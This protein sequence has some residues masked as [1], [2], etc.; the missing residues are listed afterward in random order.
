MPPPR[1]CPRGNARGAPW[2]VTARVRTR[3]DQTDGADADADAEHRKASRGDK[4]RRN[5]GP[6]AL[7]LTRALLCS[8][9]LPVFSSCF[10]GLCKKGADVCESLH[11][12]DLSKM[13]FCQFVIDYG[14]CHNPDCLFNHARPKE[15]E[16]K[17]CIW[18]ARGF[19]K[20]GPNCKSRHRKREMCPDYLAGFCEL[21]PAC[22]KGHPKW[23]LPA[24]MDLGTPQYDSAGNLIPGSDQ[25]RL[26]SLRSLI[27]MAMP[28][29]NLL[30]GGSGGG[31]ATKERRTQTLDE[32]QCNL[33]KQFGHMA[34]AC[35]NAPR[36]PPGLVGY[37]HPS[38]GGGGGVVRD[39]SIV[40]CF[41][42]GEIG[43]YANVCRGEKREPPEGG[44]VLPSGV[45][46]RDRMNTKRTRDNDGGL[47]AMPQ[48]MF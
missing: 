4:V 6:G 10:L 18:Y 17:D 28:T 36:P 22:P 3:L 20:L 45:R 33:C 34:G 14:S 21:G 11:I 35:P 1:R 2:G 9:C 12:Y 25:P 16:V 42:C 43:H 39:L 31:G 26:R 8:V 19:C 40:Q 44:W 46:Q 41:R 38:G 47:G 48:R 5:G 27:G 13:P 37:G 29:N 15:R 24:E 7:M 32:I 23:L 30:S